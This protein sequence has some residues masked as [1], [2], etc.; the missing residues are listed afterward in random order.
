KP[1]T[2]SLSFTSHAQCCGCGECRFSLEHN[3]GNEYA[4]LNLGVVYQ[5]TG[6]PELARRTYAEIIRLTLGPPS[7]ISS[8]RATACPSP[9]SPLASPFVS[10]AGAAPSASPSTAGAAPAYR[11]LPQPGRR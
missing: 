3:P 4:L 11:V 7:P 10:A 8:A 1:S 5:D 2:S 6:R 9:L